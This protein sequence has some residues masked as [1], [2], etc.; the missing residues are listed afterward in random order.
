MRGRDWIAVA[1]M[2]L[3]LVVF[4]GYWANAKADCNKQGGA[5]VQAPF[6]FSCVARP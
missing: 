5:L 4:C 2:V 6:G 3:I 1:L